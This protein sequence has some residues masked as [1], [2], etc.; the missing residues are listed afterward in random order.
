MSP[1]ASIVTSAAER[2]TW[3]VSDVI[4]DP[5]TSTRRS[6]SHLPHE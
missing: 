1:I 2:F 5:E 6:D 3:S 4:E